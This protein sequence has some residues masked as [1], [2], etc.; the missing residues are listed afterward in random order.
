MERPIAYDKLAREDRFVR[1]RARRVGEIRAEQGLPRMPDLSSTESIRERV[2]GILVGEL[3]AMEGAGRTVYE[4][5]AAPW[6]FTMDMARQTWD[7][8]R[9][10]EV[11]S[12]LL[13]HLGGLHRGVPRDND[14]LALRLRGVP[15]TERKAE[16]EALLE[17]VNLKGT[18]DKRIHELS[19][20]MRQR[21]ALA[22]ALGQE[23]SVLL[24][25]EPFA[26]LD[27]ITR[28]VLHEELTRVWSESKMSV[29]FESP[30]G[31]KDAQDRDSA[32]GLGGVAAGRSLC[33]HRRM[34]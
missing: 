25:D 3:Q 33:L 24:M 7:E 11:F 30:M 27:A 34:Q 17:R 19:G 8:S 16:A 31:G 13:E 9:H 21:V 10:V 2:H 22:R 4:C 5:P 29:I 6:E 12:R 18:Y 14:P 15:R 1:M 26:A 32:R 23:P 28:D 20:G